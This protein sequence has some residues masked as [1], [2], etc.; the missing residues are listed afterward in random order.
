[1][2]FV[3]S[4]P[5]ASQACALTHSDLTEIDGPFA[6]YELE[7]EAVRNIPSRIIIFIIM[8]SISSKHL[9]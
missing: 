3:E 1:M 7:N 2:Y 8:I 4:T 9:P 5:V 6:N